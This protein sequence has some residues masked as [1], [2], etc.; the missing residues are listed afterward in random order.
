MKLVTYNHNGDGPHL[1]ALVDDYV[2]NLALASGG[3]LPN[4][5]LSLL[6][7]GDE[8]MAQAQQIVD[9]TNADSGTTVSE[10]QL[11]A[12]LSN[13][14]KIVAIGLNYMDHVRETGG[15]VPEFP[16]M[17]T[18]YTTSIVG[19][20][21]AIRWNPEVTSQVDWEAEL[22]VV[23]GKTATN[24]SEAEAMNYVA[25][26][27]NC[28]DVSARDLQMRPGDQWIYGKSL[29]TFC[30]LGPWFVTRDEIADPNNLSIRCEVNGEAMQDSSTGEMIFQVPYLIHYLSRGITLRPGDIITTGTPD[31]V[32]AFRKPAIFLK[33]G[34]TVTVEVEGL[35]R[36]TNSC[37]EGG[38]VAGSK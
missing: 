32:G 36:L 28:H 29:D 2:I 20:G 22:A 30:P 9:E 33:D 31:G 19:P 3:Q 17:F 34:D 13:P 24:V 26:Y 1:G 6:E 14:S 7:A 21:D 8:A 12:P 11:L 37:V 5:L 38:Q 35:G 18:K 16:T 10:V 25:G 23:I 27:M 15:K 4:D